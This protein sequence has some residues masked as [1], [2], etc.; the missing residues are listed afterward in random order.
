MTAAVGPYPSSPLGLREHVEPD[1]RYEQREAIELAF[2]AALQHLPARARAA[3]ILS[4]VVGFSARE[5]A[6]MLETSTAAVN[7]AIQRARVAL[8]RRLPE[9]SQQANAA[10]VGEKGLAKLA[11]R[12][13][14]AL[15]EGN[16]EEIVSLLTDDVVF[17]MPPDG[18]WAFPLRT[19]KM[20]AQCD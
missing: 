1:V 5:I 17:E 8:E 3:L 10:V 7:S 15:E 16:A 19:Q 4:E 2:V 20:F 11:A 18:G 13:V 14:A 9:Q 6:E 12:F